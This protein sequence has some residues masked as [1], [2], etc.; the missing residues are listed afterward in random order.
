M[1]KA[2]RRWEYTVHSSTRQS[3]LYPQQACDQFPQH[4]FSA[5]PSKFLIVSL[6]VRSYFISYLYSLLKTVWGQFLHMHIKVV[7]V[8]VVSVFT[9]VWTHMCEHIQCMLWVWKP[10]VNTMYPQSVSTSY[11]EVESLTEPG[12]S[13]VTDLCLPGTKMTDGP[14]QMPGFYGSRDLNPNPVKALPIEP[15]FLPQ[16]WLFWNG[17]R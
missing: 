11:I 4:P 15:Y 13:A 7:Y 10:H 12:A 6:N 5:S 3:P 8:Y 17:L 9:C 14:P 2:L 1:H 16:R